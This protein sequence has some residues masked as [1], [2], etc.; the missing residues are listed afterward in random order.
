[1][2]TSSFASLWILKLS[3]LLIPAIISLPV[4]IVI[5]ISIFSILKLLTCISLNHLYNYCLQS[6]KASITILGWVVYSQPTW[7]LNWHQG[8]VRW[9]HGC[10][11]RWIEQMPYCANILCNTILAVERGSCWSE[12][13][14]DGAKWLV[15]KQK[16]ISFRLFCISSFLK[17]NCIASKRKQSIK[18]EWLDGRL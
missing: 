11:V 13:K 1:M 5:I 8:L 16:I 3:S 2:I 17:W 10:W 7:E 4:L 6:P 9:Y 18:L 15:K 14:S 12:K